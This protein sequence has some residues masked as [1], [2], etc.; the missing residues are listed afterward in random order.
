MVN[1]AV[2]GI[3]LYKLLYNDYNNDFGGSVVGISGSQGS[4]KTTVC[5]D[6]VEKKIEQHPEE[7]LFWRETLKSPM[8]CERLQGSEYKLFVE[9]G[10]QLKFY[11]IKTKEQIDFEITYFKDLDHLYNMVQPG[12]LNVVFF[13]HIK[14]WTAL[15]EKCNINSNI[16][17]TVFLD[18]MEGLYY[19]GADN[20]T[21]EKMWRFMKD[22]GEV[23][24]ECRKSHTSLIGNYHDEN[25]IDHRVKNKF[26][27]YM[28]GFGAI[29]NKARSRVKQSM[30]DGCR[31]G[32]FC[33]AQG[34]NRFGKIKIDTYYPAIDNC[35]IVDYI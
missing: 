24:K 8:Q 14:K 6:L 31:M 35:I 30:V 15:I 13:D 9:K 16:W 11:K 10:L 33:I 2:E 21:K 22:S 18:E 7:L 27:F 19:A 25:L 3:R 28:Y 12:L 29:V 26:M 4:V 32:E 17:T 20:H 34:R 1:P 5:L 23:I